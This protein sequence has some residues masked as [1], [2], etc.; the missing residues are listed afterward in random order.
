M[1]TVALIIKHR[2]LPGKRNQVIVV[3]LR[4]MAPAVQQNGEHLAY[5]YCEDPSDPDTI[6]AF[7]QYRNEQAAQDFLRNDAYSA[8][9]KEV[10]S[11]LAGPPQVTNLRPIWVKAPVR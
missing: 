11:L 3:W 5:F 2:T 10:E 8:Y 6:V 9:L 7:Q 4:H 1:N